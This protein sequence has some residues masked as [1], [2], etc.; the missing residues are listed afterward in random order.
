[1]KYLKPALIVS[2]LGVIGYAIFRYY[3]KQI[4]FVKDI[5]Y[6]I[7]GLK[8]VNIAKE[9][10]TL[11]IFLK[12]Y[13][14]SNVEAKVTEIFLDVIMNGTKV[15][16]INES[17]EF[18]IM[19]T[20]TTEVSYKFSFNP[21]LVIKNIVN[22]LTLTVALKD[23]VIVADGYMKVK[24]GFLSTTVPFTYQNTLKNLLKK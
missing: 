7:S 12:V 3:K 5:Q 24:S 14:A 11:E 9:D 23:V 19:P 13:N 1:M 20:K 18:T 22:I 16:S 6:T 4:D 15:G 17:T 8:I 21:S 10:V 2:G